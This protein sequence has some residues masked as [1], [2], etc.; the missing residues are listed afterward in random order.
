ME[1][2]E[3]ETLGERITRGPLPFDE[4]LSLFRQMAE[5][6]EAAHEK[7]IIHRDLKPGNVKITPEGKVKVLDF[8][9][10]KVFSAAPAS[11]PQSESPTLTRSPSESG[12]ILGT[13]AYMSPEQA[14]GKT[15]D[16]RT[17]VWSFG[18]CLFE[19]LTG[20]A[21]FLGETVS[22]TLAKILET[23]PSW[24]ALPGQTPSRIRE[25]LARC[26]TKDPGMRLHDIA[27]ARVEIVKASEEPAELP[28]AVAT[29]VN[30]ATLAAIG[31]AGVF[32]AVALWSLTRTSRRRTAGARCS[33][34]FGRHF[35]RRTLYRLSHRGQF[36]HRERAKSL[37]SIARRD[38]S[39]SDRRKQWRRQP[40]V[41]SGQPMGRLREGSNAPAHGGERRRTA[42]HLQ[43]RRYSAW[44]GLEGRRASIF[45]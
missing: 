8:G 18:C 1:L 26:L 44:G 13:A 5:G 45:R 34:T 4:A 14:R 43:P 28:A 6:L 22:D 3:G 30:R 27:D 21:P 38:G 20:R 15:L 19:A 10:A 17:D 7:G 33:S 25:L 37:A 9:L 32:A 23:E 29:R 24:K 11:G 40:G 12:V 39:A 31:V 36:C 42:P 35:S 41:L 16:K 2:V